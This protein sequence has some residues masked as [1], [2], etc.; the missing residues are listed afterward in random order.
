MKGQLDYKIRGKP[1]KQWTIE[2]L[3]KTLKRRG[4]R[5][6]GTKPEL[7]QRLRESYKKP[8]PKQ[9]KA[10]VPKPVN[11]QEKVQVK[12]TVDVSDPMFRFYGSTYYQMPGSKMALEYLTK[13]HGLTK[14]NLNKHKTFSNLV[15]YFT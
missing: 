8:A 12:K 5:V 13:T 15:K 9:T 11:K 4:E 6:S 14:E 10:S 1:C 7:C 2:E 3:K